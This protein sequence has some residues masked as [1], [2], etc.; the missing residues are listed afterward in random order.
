MTNAGGRMASM[1]GKPPTTSASQDAPL[2]VGRGQGAVKRFG[3]LV[4]SLSA[5]AALMHWTYEN[6]ISPTFSVIGFRYRDP[7]PGLYA[8]AYLLVIFVGYFLPARLRKPSD[9]VVWV[10]YVMTCVPS[11][12]VA[13]YANIITP[14]AS[15]ELGL[16]VAT[17]FLFIILLADRGPG[18]A[19]PRLRVPAHVLWLAL[20]LIS[21]VVYGYM[22]Y[23]TGLSLR[24]MSLTGVASTRFAYQDAITASGPALGYLIGVQG[25]VINPLFMARGIY[26]RN[27]LMLAAGA[28]GQ[29]LIFS[30]TGYKMMILSVPAALLIPLI[31]QRSSTPFGRR[32]IDGVVAVGLIALLVDRI[33]GAFE[34]TFIFFGRLVLIPGALTAAHVLVFAG[35]PKAEWGYS[36]LKSF[37]DYPYSTTPALLVGAEFSHDA[38][39]SAN[40]SFLGDGYAN[41][42]YPGIFIEAVMVVLL[43]WALDGAAKGLPMKAT[44]IIL[45]VPSIAL[46]NTSAFTGIIT[47]G[48]AFAVLILMGLPREGWGRDRGSSVD[49]RV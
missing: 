9:F 17:S 3:L 19:L 20:S 16:V 30:V 4:L 15:T 10:L 6:S 45:L 18:I 24:F 43:L 38:R 29:M 27:W 42:G 25:N 46:V 31:F 21:A 7:D 40:A 13:Q 22:M 34:Y 39:V 2:R 48:C 23:V 12:L 35:E 14:E 1:H 49:S 32:I 47:G 8:I 44:C 41:L 36:F 11:I 37:V 26:S 33:V 28:I 5:Y